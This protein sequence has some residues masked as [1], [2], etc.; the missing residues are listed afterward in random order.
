MPLKI[1]AKYWSFFSEHLPSKFQSKRMY[2]RKETFKKYVRSRSPSFNRPAPSPLVCPCLFSNNLHLLFLPKVHSFWLEL[3]LSPSISILVKIRENKLIMSTSIFGWN[4]YKVDTIGAWQKCPLYG[5]VRFIDSP[6]KN[7]KSWKVNMK[8]TICHDFPSPDL[9]EQPKD[10]K[11]NENGKFFSFW[12][13]QTRFPTLLHLT[14]YH[15]VYIIYNQW[16]SSHFWWKYAKK[17]M[18]SAEKRMRSC[19]K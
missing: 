13:L 16:I 10:G 15:E 17:I 1:K 11:I 9:L 4:L 14:T 12:S 19:G 2:L 7:Q 5:D 8:S 3:T 18:D 6:S